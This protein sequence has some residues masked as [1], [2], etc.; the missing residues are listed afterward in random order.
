[1]FEMDDKAL[2]DQ[3]TYCKPPV[4]TPF[5]MLMVWGLQSFSPPD[6][7]SVYFFPF[8]FIVINYT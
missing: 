7:V 4:I 6:I 3:M 5:S 1:M 8:I 2:C